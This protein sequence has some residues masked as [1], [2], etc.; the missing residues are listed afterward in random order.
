MQRG[1]EKLSLFHVLRD[2]FAASCTGRPFGGD[3]G[4]HYQQAAI[5]TNREVVDA[6]LYMIVALLFPSLR[7]G[8]SSLQ[9]PRRVAVRAERPGLRAAAD[10]PVKASLHC[11]LYTSTSPIACVG[12]AVTHVQR[13]L[14]QLDKA[15]FP[16]CAASPSRASYTTCETAYCRVC[17][18]PPTGASLR[19]DC[20]PGA[21]PAA[22]SSIEIPSNKRLASTKAQVQQKRY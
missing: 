7:E 21:L 9:Q 10:D 17:Y 16:S 1:V 3:G 11:F 20:R 13:P 18:S 6:A 8:P 15:G 22:V 5:W 14:P 2:G 19:R 4:R 12:A